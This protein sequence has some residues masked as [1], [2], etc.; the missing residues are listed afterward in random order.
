MPAFSVTTI[1]HVV[2]R[3]VDV[4]SMIHFYCDTLGFTVAKRNE[5]LGLIHLRGGNAMVDLVAASGETGRAGGVAA[6]REGRNM[7]HLCLRIEPFDLASLTQY[8][9]AKGV[10]LQDPHTRFGAQ[11]DG[12]SFYISDPEGNR[13]ELK[14]LIGM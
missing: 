9:A 4:Q 10:T 11:G 5:K 13:V 8:F 12:L 3:C 14:G 1:D 6:G 7:D 2:L